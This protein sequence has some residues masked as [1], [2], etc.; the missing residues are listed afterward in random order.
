[1]S[2]TCANSDFSC[3]KTE[4]IAL[5]SSSLSE[6]CDSDCRL[7]LGSRVIGR[8]HEKACAKSAFR[9]PAVLSTC[10]RNRS[11]SSGASFS[12]RVFALDVNFGW[13]DRVAA[14][15][16]CSEIG[17]NAGGASSPREC[18]AVTTCDNSSR[19]STSRIS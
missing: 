6:C 13:T 2:V 3:A 14:N 19:P 12:S 16:S 7:R 18:P 5:G 11:A 1:M 17:A 8:R 15:T 10:L 9:G 4:L